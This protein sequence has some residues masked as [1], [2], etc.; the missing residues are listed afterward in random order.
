MGTEEMFRVKQIAAELDVHPRT[1][2]NWIISGKLRV[3]AVL[4]GGQYRITRSDVERL[5]RTEELRVG[6]M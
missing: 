5:L 2:R 3:A 6:T 1:V 4:P